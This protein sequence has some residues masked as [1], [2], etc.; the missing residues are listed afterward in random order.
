MRALEG[1]TDAEI[2]AVTMELVVTRDRSK[3]D[4]KAVID[5]VRAAGFEAR[6]K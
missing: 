2:D 1:V 5:A 3:I 4:L 6:P